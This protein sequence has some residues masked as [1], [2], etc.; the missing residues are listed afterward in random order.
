MLGKE[1]TKDGE[2]LRDWQQKET[3]PPLSLKGPEEREF[4]F[5]TLG[6]GPPSRSCGHGQNSSISRPW[7]G[8]DRGGEES[9]S[10]CFSLQL[11]PSLAEFQEQHEDKGPY[12]WASWGT[13][14]GRE[15]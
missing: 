15:R 13:K 7:P 4:V 6:E 8:W 10:C 12:G 5:E 9:T 3:L 11:I 2:S 14:Q 1:P